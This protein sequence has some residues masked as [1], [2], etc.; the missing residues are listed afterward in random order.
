MRAIKNVFNKLGIDGAI[1]FTSIFRLLQASSGL[2]SILFVAN[3]LTD[4][5]QGYYYTSIS[6]TAL[7][8]FFELGLSKIIKTENQFIINRDFICEKPLISI[9]KYLDKLLNE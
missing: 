4:I 5:E 3:Y 1:M 6:L 2:I 9:N 7:Q 8:I